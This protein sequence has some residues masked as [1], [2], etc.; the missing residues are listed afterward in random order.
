MKYT[1]FTEQEILT[2][3]SLIARGS[4]TPG[5]RN[6]VAIFERERMRRVVLEVVTD[7]SAASRDFIYS[8]VGVDG[9]DKMSEELRSRIDEALV[10]LCNDGAITTN[11]THTVY[12]A[13][14]LQVSLGAEMAEAA[15]R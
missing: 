9:Q 12:V 7:V 14:G 5:V 3:T 13:K 10:E 1:P 15:R 8:S 4:S 6:D 11:T 2:L